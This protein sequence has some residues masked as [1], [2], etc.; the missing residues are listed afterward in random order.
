VEIHPGNGDGHVVVVTGAAGGVGRRV[1]QLLAADPTV[2]RVVALDLLPAPAEAAVPKVEYHRVD[3]TAADLGPLLER[4]DELVH[5][6]MVSDTERRRRRSAWV[7][8]TGTGRM[9][10]AAAA[11]G[12]RHVVA[13]SSATV[14]G[15]WPNNPVPLTE[16][17][18][19][20]PNPGLAHAVQR[21]Q[22]EHLLADWADA[23]VDRTA[24][25]LRPVT[26]LDEDATSWMARALAAASGMRAGDDDPPKQFVHL[27]D[28][29]AAVALARREHLD[30]PFNVT[31]DGWL[32]GDVVRALSGTAPRF[33]LPPRLAAWFARVRWRFQRGPIPPGLVPY[34]E[35]AVLVSNDRLVAAGWSPAWTNEE[36]LVAGTEAKWFTLLSP[37]RKQELA[38]GTAGALA[39]LVALAAALGVRAAVRRRR[40]A[41][42]ARP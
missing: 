17:A 9:L 2:E 13:M 22:A 20:R 18:P 25:V 36:A 6:A 35:H 8:V 24:A 7:N 29:A 33:P 3:V 26:A 12:V 31:P 28:L 11:A 21:A 19:L 27:D 34:T 38:L 40:R 14:Y 37:K 5:L 41:V 15:A 23:Q 10:D 1:L 39:V 30:G 4:A 16:D 32:A 42:A